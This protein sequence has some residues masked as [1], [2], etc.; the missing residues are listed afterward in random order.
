MSY[1]KK[2]GFTTNKNLT[3]Y[4]TTPVH[5]IDTHYLLPSLVGSFEHCLEPSG[6]TQCEEIYNKTVDTWRRPTD[7]AFPQ[8]PWA[9]MPLLPENFL[10]FFS[11]YPAILLTWMLVKITMLQP[12]LLTSVSDNHVATFTTDKCLTLCDMIAN[13]FPLKI[14]IS[15]FYYNINFTCHHHMTQTTISVTNLASIS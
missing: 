2:Y 5:K 15:C 7:R 4:V 8:L 13:I 12:S 9:V 3:I 6:S 14:F 1:L 11:I 10:T